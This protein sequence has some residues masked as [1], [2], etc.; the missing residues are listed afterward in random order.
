[1]KSALSSECSSMLDAQPATVYPTSPD[2]PSCNSKF[3]FWSEHHYIYFLTI[4]LS[5]IVAVGMKFDPT[6]RQRNLSSTTALVVI[7]IFFSSH[8]ELI[9]F[10][11]PHNVLQMCHTA[12]YLQYF[13][14]IHCSTFFKFH[15]LFHLDLDLL[16]HVQI[17]LCSYFIYRPS[18]KKVYTCIMAYYFHM[19]VNI[20]TWM[21]NIGRIT[22][23]A[24]NTIFCQE[25]YMD[26]NDK[27][28]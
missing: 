12:L 2:D 23:P 9:S 18:Q 11:D 24:F 25:K 28:W 20:W 5:T 13:S 7:M 10:Q 8:N 26:F 27:Y 1:M 15:S 14:L 17:H 16:F 6:C 22:I 4:V 21:T 3:G 19:E